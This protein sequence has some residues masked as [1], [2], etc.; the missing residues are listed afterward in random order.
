MAD[1]YFHGQVSRPCKVKVTGDDLASAMHRAAK[2][3]YDE[4]VEEYGGAMNT[5]F[6]WDGGVILDANEEE[7]E[8]QP[9][10]P[11]TNDNELSCPDCGENHH[12]EQEC[13][14]EDTLI[15]ADWKLED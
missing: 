1:W 8:P 13:P 4:L 7:I 6:E 9:E 3:E 10:E 14:Q 5:R 2:D 12:E 11:E 15:P